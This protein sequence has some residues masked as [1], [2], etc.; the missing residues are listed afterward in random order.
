M[1][2]IGSHCEMR[3]LAARF[4]FSRFVRTF[5]TALTL[6]TSAFGEE[7]VN[8]PH[9]TDRG[10]VM[11]I[12]LPSGAS[13]SQVST[14]ET[15]ATKLGGIFSVKFPIIREAADVAAIRLRVADGPAPGALERESYTIRTSRERGIELTGATDLALRHAAW[16]LLHR[17]GYRQF[18]PGKNWEIVPKLK[19]FSLSLNVKESPDY[20]NRRIWYGYGSWDR[21][22]GS[23][24]DW[25]E[26]NRMGGGF[27]LN[28][29]HAYGQLVRSQQK[30]FDA[31]PE[32]FALVDG[33]RRVVP[34]AKLCISNPGVR[35]AAVAYA[36]QFFEKNPEADSVSVDP[37]DGG[38]W[39]ECA[40]CVKMGPPNDRATIL[41]NTVAEGV[42][43]KLGPNRYV[44]MY[45]YNYHSEPPS[46]KVH[47]NVII[48]VATAFIKGGLKLDDLISGWAARGATLGIREY[49]SVNTWDRDLPGAAR[50][51][52]LDYLAET[53]PAFHEKGARFLSAE[54]SE[55]FGPNGLGYYFAARM[56]WDVDEAKRKDAIVGDFL[57]LSFGPAREPMREFYARIDGGN[58]K[59]RLVFDDQLA[60]MF[61]ALGEARKLAGD[62]AGI[63]A[64]IDDLVLYTRH[65][66]LYS[67][68][69]NAPAGPE[70]QAAYEAMI[71]HAY[72]TRRSSMV[73]SYALYRDVSARD[74]SIVVPE[75]ARWQ[76]K[77]GANPWKSSEPFSNDEIEAMLGSGIANHTPVDL[78]FEPREYDDLTVQPARRVLGELPDLPP[79]AAESGRGDRSW[80]TVVEKAPATIE[81]RVTGGLIAHYRDRGNVKIKLWKLGGASATGESETLVTGDESVPP[82]GV[83][84]TVRLTAKEPG[85]Y[86]IDLADGSDLTRVTWPEGQ[87]MSWKMSLDDFPHM[88]G[89]R[90]SLYAWVP[91]GTKKIGL[92]A[93]SS[94]GELR[95]PDGKKAADLKAEEGTFLSVAVPEGMDG[96]FWR[97]Q[98]VAG[99]ISLLNIPPYLARRPTELVVPAE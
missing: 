59:A 94:G 76:V 63:R 48:S 46:V 8:L 54:S 80:F 38:H 50:G 70:R 95:L 11:P 18:F 82:D 34:E 49:Y 20:A 19:S 88:M 7:A 51:S 30:T 56:M 16:D 78:D 67:R 25:V 26:K 44:G 15:L 87:L 5:L 22:D 47:P 81:L 41:A 72:R 39:C 77:E 28:T 32:Y 85:I 42:T 91:K 14:A 98:G 99:R 58:A 75:N 73:H 4:F 57:D 64:R 84:R 93:K 61:R 33:E 27:A 89:G 13:E 60:R 74:K 53:I 69:Q 23:Y 37:S 90:W 6:L 21:E 86:R 36:L 45:A 71:R 40:D 79:G 12:W 52:R 55:N 92:Y 96:A 31:H 35:D 24:R 97:F 66:E 2:R 9:I 43:K 17:L 65:A 62:D 83:E 29:G 68:Y 1:A 3:F 10:G